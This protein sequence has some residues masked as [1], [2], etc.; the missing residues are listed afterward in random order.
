M[1]D[2][3]R[4]EEC[5]TGFMEYLCKLIR[6]FGSSWMSSGKL[7]YFILLHYLYEAENRGWALTADFFHNREPAKGTW[8][9]FEGSVIKTITLW[10]AAR[11]CLWPLPIDLTKYTRSL[12]YLCFLSRN[13]CG[14][15]RCFDS[16]I[17]PELMCRIDAVIK[18]AN[19]LIDII[20]GFQKPAVE[21][22]EKLE[23]AIVQM[24]MLFPVLPTVS[25]GI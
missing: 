13:L 12:G 14:F 15:K 1:F 5:L 8:L 9:A 21:E 4:T 6:Y 10:V 23:K 7:V 18:E 24:F 16:D 22:W 17:S 19:G 3:E 20:D 2:Y 11:S 25:R